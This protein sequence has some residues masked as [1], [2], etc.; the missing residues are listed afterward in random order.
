MKIHTYTL[1]SGR[2][3]K[4]VTAFLKQFQKPFDPT[5]IIT[6]RYAAKH[7]KTAAAVK[8]EW[9]EKADRSVQRGK[10][11]HGYLECK[12]KGEPLPV[13]PKQHEGFIQVIESLYDK[14]TS[15]YDFVNAEKILFS[16]HYGLAGTVDLIMRRGDDFI[17][18]DYKT[19]EDFKKNN[20]FESLLSPFQFS[21]ASHLNIYSL[22][23]S[24]YRY[25][26][27][28]EEYYKTVRTGIVWVK[29]DGYEF[30]KPVDFDGGMNVV[31]QRAA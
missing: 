15:C 18:M 8:K 21:E 25:I 16:P 10:L 31:Y 5:G 27:L 30:I 29:P 23:L 19:N 20:H 2:K 28:K 9:K 1:E 4:S 11:V 3:L 17:I 6:R 26:A 7:G 13:M 14:L 22:Q 12:F 24:V